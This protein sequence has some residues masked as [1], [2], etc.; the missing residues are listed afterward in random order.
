MTN[1]I[2]IHDLVRR[3]GTTYAA[4]FDAIKATGLRG[5]VVN[6][7]RVWTR[8]EVEAIRAALAR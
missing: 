6:G 5:R 1:R 3:L 4:A 7:T 2:S 8:D